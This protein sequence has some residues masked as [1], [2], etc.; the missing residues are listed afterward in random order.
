MNVA[1]KKLIL[2]GAITAAC[3]IIAW[4]KES[5]IVFISSEKDNVI[6]VLDGKTQQQIAVIKT[7]KRPRHMQFTADRER[8]IALCGDDGS[9]VIVDIAGK[10]VVDKIKLQEGAEMF[11]LSPDGKTFYFSNED[12]AQIVFVDL[13]TKEVIKKIK[14]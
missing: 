9:A 2:I 3:P 12:D 1:F 10:K 14:A 11:D 6:T 13:A 4:S 5:G 7:C 8:L